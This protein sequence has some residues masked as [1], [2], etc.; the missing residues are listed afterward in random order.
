MSFN[1]F[2]SNILV[3]LNK[4]HQNAENYLS[5]SSLLK[6]TEFKKRK[7]FDDPEPCHCIKIHD[8]AKTTG[9]WQKIDYLKLNLRQYQTEISSD[10]QRTYRKEKKKESCFAAGAES[11]LKGYKDKLEVNI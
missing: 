10:R 1:Y 6:I 3:G 7:Q 8:S 5:L 9:R 2:R 4:L 11:D